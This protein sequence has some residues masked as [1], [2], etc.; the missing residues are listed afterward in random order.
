MAGQTL[1]VRSMGICF[2]PLPTGTP[3]N[4][5]C[6]ICSLPMPLQKLQRSLHTGI[7]REVDDLEVRHFGPH[8]GK[9]C[10]AV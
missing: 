2:S 5:S 1:K 3:E 6:W 7:P 10:D 8:T 9:G 4:R